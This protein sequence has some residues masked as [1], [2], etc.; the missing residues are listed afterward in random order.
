MNR[1]EFF[2]WLGVTLV[3][4]FVVALAFLLIEEEKDCRAR[5]G[6]LLRGLNGN[7]CVE[8]KRLK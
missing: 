4:V 2:C 8:V 6:E 3:V 5:G 1:T 7:L